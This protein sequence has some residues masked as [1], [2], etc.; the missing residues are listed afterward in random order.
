M[1]LNEMQKKER[2]EFLEKNLTI[3]EC[4]QN[5]KYVF[6]SY[7]S[8]NWETVFKD[9]VVPLQKE[10][11]MRVYADKAFDK[12][13]D[14][15]IIPMLRN[16]RGA[17]AVVAFVS[18]SYIESYACF[19]ELLTAVNNNVPVVFVSLND[20]LKL[21]DTTDQPDIERGVKKEIIRQGD[22]LATKTNNTSNDVM[23]AM[24]SAYTSLSTLLE[25]DALAKYDI[26]DA[27]IN[28]F[29]DAAVNK[30]TVNDLKAL[31]RSVRSVSKQVFDEAAVGKSQSA[32][33]TAGSAAA[34]AAP[35]KSPAPAKGAPAALAERPEPKAPNKL[36]SIFGDPK[37]RN[38]III[39]AAALAVIAAAV[40]IFV[41]NAG[42]SSSGMDTIK[43]DGASISMTYTGNYKR[44]KPNGEGSCTFGENLLGYLEFEGLWENGELNS[45]KLTKTLKD[46]NGRPIG[47]QV[48]RGVFVNNMPNG[49]GSETGYDENGDILYI[50]EGEFKDGNYNGQG[51]LTDYYENGN[52]RSTYEGEFED[53]K[54]SGKGK[55]TDHDENVNVS[56]TYEGE[57]EDDQYNGQGKLINYDENGN[58][59]T[60]FEGKFKN[61]RFV[62]DYD[63]VD[64][65]IWDFIYTG[66]WS[67]GAPNGY[68]TAVFEN[69]YVYEGDWKDGQKNG[70][71]KE[72]GYD[73]NGKVTNIYEGD[74]VNGLANG[75]GT[76]TS[77]HANGK[78]VYVY[79]G[80]FKNGKR[81]GY[82]TETGYDENGKVITRYEGEWKDY[83]QNGQCKQTNYDKNGTITWSF[84]GEL[85]DGNRNGQGTE[86][87]YIDGIISY[88]YE[89]EYKDDMRNGYGTNTDYDENGR[90]TWTYDGEWSDGKRSGQGKD[91]EYNENGIIIR[92]YEGEWKEDKR[93]GSFVVTTYDE[94]GNVTDT[95]NEVWQDDRRVS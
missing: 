22:N 26:S 68:G 44:G 53:G 47:T 48:F 88:S 90:I 87:G 69:G 71:G 10:Y 64:V 52:V 80:E 73:E 62:R 32:T 1:A 14:K 54:Y 38:I 6:I 86:T 49:Q 83:K 55:L 51:K 19:L 28:F 77:Y 95:S 37:K 93:N 17:E 20:D 85:K 56:S 4:S 11:G 24:K 34:P 89:G 66:E 33:Q 75:H 79:E 74:W 91:T 27:F 16:I 7:A 23:R 60:T 43:I 82:G 12:E 78:D 41:L 30:K 57:F 63:V 59:K 29:R 76:Q 35:A 70:Y 18:Q 92:T 8:D 3:T 2:S 46:R 72:T 58:I 9:A 61:G 81:N 15:W 36:K 84:E 67:N 25:Q 5:K 65:K 31:K 94:N 39:S 13:N 21:G 50:F 42:S 40:I 45:G